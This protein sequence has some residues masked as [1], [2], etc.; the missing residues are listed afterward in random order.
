GLLKRTTVP[1]PIRWAID[2]M[3]SL[4]VGLPAALLGF[5]LL[6]A[7]TGAPLNLYGTTAIIIVAYVTLMLPHAIRPQLSTLLA[8]SNEYA[9]ASLVSGS[10][11]LR[12]ALRITLPLVRTGVGVASAMVVVL[13]FHEFAASVL[14]RSPQ[15]QVMGTLLF[16]EWSSG[17]QS[18][19]AVI[20]LVMVA[21][22]TVGVG[23]ALLVGGRQ[24]LN[25]L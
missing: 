11:P 17:T 4:S 12:T 9:E 8:T 20:S 6:F 21:V 19:V 14:V 1:G 22:T 18:G 2:F 10:G 23:L 13:V 24:A 3:S 5:W 16:D 25:R 7:Y 15:T